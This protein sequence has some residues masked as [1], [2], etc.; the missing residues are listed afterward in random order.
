[1][2]NRAAS[3][4]ALVFG[5]MLAAFVMLW[6][7]VGDARLAAAMTITAFSVLSLVG[8]GWGMAHLSHRQQLRGEQPAIYTPDAPPAPPARQLPEPK[9]YQLT[10]QQWLRSDRIDAEAQRIAQVLRDHDAPP[11]R[12]S[13]AA[14]A[15]IFGHET[16]RALIS[17]WCQWGWCSTPSQGVA[18]EWIDGT[19]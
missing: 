10:P 11:T 12:D 17:K 19:Q 2:V 16:S 18:A 5:V 9:F 7:L 3:A 13:I 1:M 8:L 4:F 6:V 15:Q 14:Y